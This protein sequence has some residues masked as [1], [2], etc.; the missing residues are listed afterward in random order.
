MKVMNEISSINTYDILYIHVAAVQW[1]GDMSWED[2]LRE[3]H[4]NPNDVVS[5]S[6]LQK[7]LP[8]W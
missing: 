4:Y 6:G 2:Y 7:N 1:R 8:F 3:I 5:F